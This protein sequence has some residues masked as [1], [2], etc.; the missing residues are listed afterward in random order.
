MFLWILIFFIYHNLVKRNHEQFK[1]KYHFSTIKYVPFTTADSTVPGTYSKHPNL[2]VTFKSKHTFKSEHIFP[3]KNLRDT[4]L[5]ALLWITWDN[6][7]K[8]FSPVPPVNWWALYK[9]QLV[10]LIGNTVSSLAGIYMLLLSNNC[11]HHYLPWRRHLQLYT[12]QFLTWN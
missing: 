2:W 10:L 5:T 9:C 12:V 4:Y 6:A 8:I 3:P 11:R 1:A 7:C